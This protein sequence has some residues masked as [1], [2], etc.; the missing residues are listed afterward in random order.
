[1]LGPNALAVFLTFPIL[2]LSAKSRPKPES[3]ELFGYNKDFGGA[4]LFYSGGK[5]EQTPSIILQ[6]SSIL[7]YAYIG[8]S[9]ELNVSD[10]VVVKCK[11]MGS[12]LRIH[13][14]RY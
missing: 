4:P 12:K 9:N 2:A 14:E 6:S 10:A 3:F 7:G 11:F 5:S 8:D 13:R 1:M